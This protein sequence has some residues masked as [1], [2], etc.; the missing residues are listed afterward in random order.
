MDEWYV[1][2]AERAVQAGITSEITRISAQVPDAT[3]RH[4]HCRRCGEEITPE[5]RQGLGYD[6]CLHCASRAE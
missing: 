1:E 5:G 4:V 3:V 2:N 6:T